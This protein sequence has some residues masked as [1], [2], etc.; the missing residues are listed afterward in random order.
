MN[1]EFELFPGKN[2]SELFKDI[3]TNQ[4]HK[5]QRI[6]LLINDIRKVI[7][8]SNNRKVSDY[9]VLG[10]ILKD[11]VDSS[12]KN[13]DS[14]V[15][16]ATLAQRIISSTITS[17]GSDGI[18]SEVEKSQLMKEL[19]EEVDNVVKE[20]AELTESKIDELSDE[21]DELKEKLKS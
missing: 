4:Q 18:L 20:A 8:D 7:K 19:E 2:L 9:A 17:D 6:S 16:L 12:I 3:Y 21:M 11:L 10:P 14:L 13:D 15:K 5:K 1:T